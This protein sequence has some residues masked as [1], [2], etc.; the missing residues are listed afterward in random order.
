M[1]QGLVSYAVQAHEVQVDAVTTPESSF[2]SAL[3]RVVELTAAVEKLEDDGWTIKDEFL[4]CSATTSR[5][6]SAGVPAPET[7]DALTDAADLELTFRRDSA[8]FE[9]SR[10]RTEKLDFR[11]GLPT[12]EP[13]EVFEEDELEQARE[14]WAGDADAAKRLVGTWSAKLT[15]DLAAPLSAVGGDV[16]WRVVRK[17]T[18]LEKTI[19]SY[20]WWRIRELVED[21]ERPVAV[22]VTA[23][24]DLYLHTPAF[25]VVSA[26]RVRDTDLRLSTLATRRRRLQ[27]IAANHMPAG[28][29]V[30]EQLEFED[31]KHGTDAPFVALLRQYADASAW[32]WL[33]NL[34][35]AA[36]D[37]TPATLEYFGYRR[38]FFTI[39][40]TGFAAIDRAFDL[41]VWATA[42]ESPDRILATR[43]VI[44]LHQADTLPDKPQEVIRAAEPLYLALRASE[45]AAVLESQRQ[46]RA[47]AVDAARESAAAAQSAAKSAAERTIAS[48]AAVAGIVVANATAGLSAHDARGFSIGIV[49]L[50]G[51]LIVWA[52]AVEGPTM[53]APLSSFAA[54]IGVI[55]NL[56][57]PEERGTILKMTALAKASHAVW[58]ARIASPLVY[59]A[60]AVI[61][62]AI[63]HFRFD[64]L[65]HI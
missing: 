54:D 10:S 18:V 14:A 36:D 17:A 12:G 38:R 52:V 39:D 42:E 32:A 20:P 24:Q 23:E 41:Y 13:D 16:S 26:D 34:M 64:L 33:S 28:V 53:R 51:F 31:D 47:I 27:R 56:I 37:A 30:P 29:A 2:S 55:A 44:S 63:A 7:L 6:G 9:L 48:L 22:I 43:Q 60:G 50:F 35:D 5:P 45:V 8:S 19:A 46:A 62:L 25:A 3:E 59:L 4:V 58:R 40:R 61:T 65:P 21:H 11:S 57:G 1:P 49:A 15:L